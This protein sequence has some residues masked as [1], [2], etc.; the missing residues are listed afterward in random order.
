MKWPEFENSGLH[1]MMEDSV[2]HLVDDDADDSIIGLDE[3]P[4][5]T[6]DLDS[7]FISF[8]DNSEDIATETRPK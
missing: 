7:S 5:D 3:C 2:S 8:S 6:D 4:I 1:E